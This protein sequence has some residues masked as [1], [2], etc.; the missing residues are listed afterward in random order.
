MP[1]SLASS[2]GHDLTASHVLVR[3]KP[4]EIELRIKIATD[5]AWPLVQ[6]NVPGVVF[7][8]EDFETVGRPILLKFGQTLD[9]LR[10]SERILS[11]IRTDVVLAEDVFLFISVYPR[12]PKGTLRI[13]ETYLGKPFPGYLSHVRLFDESGQLITTK[14]LSAADPIFEFVVPPAKPG[15]PSHTEPEKTK[16]LP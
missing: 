4:G 16:P 10:V 13:N 1:L 12:P 11:P 15:K 14:T 5:I 7:L 2:W 8:R 6:E 9:E 3:L